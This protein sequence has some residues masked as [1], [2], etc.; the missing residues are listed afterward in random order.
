MNSKVSSSNASQDFKVSPCLKDQSTPVFPQ[1]YPQMRENQGICL[2]GS[3]LAHTE[4]VPRT[5]YV[6]WTSWPVRA[7]RPQT[8]KIIANTL[9]YS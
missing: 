1:Q 8:L 9:R 2:S 7:Q 6:F 5:V 4:S 3:G